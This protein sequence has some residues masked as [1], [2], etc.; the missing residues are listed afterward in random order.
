LLIFVM[1]SY[2][3]PVLVIVFGGVLCAIVTVVPFD[4]RKRNEITVQRSTPDSATTEILA[5]LDPLDAASTQPISVVSGTATG[6]GSKRSTDAGPHK[7]EQRD[8][9]RD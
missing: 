7:R 9:T 3:V 8:I 6:T 5:R 1:Q 4:L 2:T